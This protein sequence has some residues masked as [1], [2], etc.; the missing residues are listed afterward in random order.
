[1]RKI[2]PWSILEDHFAC[3]DRVEEIKKSWPGGLPITKV[4]LRS[5]LHNNSVFTWHDIEW[6]VYEACTHEACSEWYDKTRDTFSVITEADIELTWHVLTNRMGA[7][8]WWRQQV[9]DWKPGKK[10]AEA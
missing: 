8:G 6:L 10:G 5:L 9:L 1:M 7:K 3:P 2:I 4:A